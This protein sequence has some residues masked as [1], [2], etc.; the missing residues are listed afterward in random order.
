MFMNNPV[1]ILCFLLT[2]MLL[3]GALIVP[4]Q[5]AAN[6]SNE[7]I[8]RLSPQHYMFTKQETANTMP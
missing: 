2:F 8:G 4:I 3:S 5:A 1:K 6:K 7:T